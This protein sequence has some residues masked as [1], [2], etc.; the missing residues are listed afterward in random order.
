VSA[1]ATSIASGASAR[2]TSVPSKSRN[3]DAGSSDESGGGDSA[4]ASVGK[5]APESQEGSGLRIADL[6][7]SPFSGEK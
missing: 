2:S 1:G 4:M 6:N 3:K 5:A 7:D